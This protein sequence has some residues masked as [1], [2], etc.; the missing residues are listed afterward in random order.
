MENKLQELESEALKQPYITNV[1][2][3]LT[4]AVDRAE[5][6]RDQQVAKNTE[7]RRALIIVEHFLRKTK[8]LCYGGM[9]INA[10]LP[11]NLKF[12][13]FSKTLPD[14]DFF[15]PVPEDDCDSLIE[16]LNKGKFDNVSKRLG[17]HEGTY[18]IFVNYHGVADITY[19]SS[20]LYKKLYNTSITEDNIHYVDANYLRLGMYLELSRPRG[21]VERWDKVYKR[22]ILLNHVKS[23]IYPECKKMYH[24]NFTIEENIF[25][26]ILDYCIDNNFIY[27]GADIAR[28]YESGKDRAGFILKENNPFIVYVKN[29]VSHLSKL[30]QIIYTA[31]KHSTIKIVHW[32]RLTDIVPE[33]YGIKIN[34]HLSILIIEEIYCYSYNT[35]VIPKH[36]RLK[37]ASLDTAIALFFTLSYLRSLDELVP[38]TILCFA[39]HLVEISKMTRDMNK[40]GVFP[41]FVINC[42]GHQPTKESLIKAKVERVT[43]YKIRELKKKTKR[44]GKQ[45]LGKRT[46]KQRRS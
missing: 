5:E 15:S 38:G 12:Y 30:R 11:A 45:Y 9:A 14:Y 8:R 44:R 18:K 40:S 29:A 36:G 41:P 4:D 27:C 16:L 42:Q 23:T 31:D 21:E 7:L 13:D 34:G 3:T 46:R 25:S 37:I 19:M 33:M 1:L 2:H 17:I 35:V 6:I 20:W 43:E 26:I 10:H 22:L 39:H 32:E 28:I 24:K